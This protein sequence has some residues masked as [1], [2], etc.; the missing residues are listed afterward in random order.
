VARYRLQYSSAYIED[1]KALEAFDRAKVRNAVL[2]L[3]DQAEVP[4]RNRR[5]LMSPVSW[6]PEATWKLRIEDYRLFYRVDAATVF[7]LRVRFKGS[8][9][10]E[11]MG[12]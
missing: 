2:A 6:C 11:E 9:T 3:G 12:S 5:P 4:T 1:F 7:V 8:R 10:I